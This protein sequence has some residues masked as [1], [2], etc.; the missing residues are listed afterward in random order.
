MTTP[1]I[2]LIDPTGGAMAR[3][4]FALAPRPADL[5]GARLGLLDN[6]KSGSEPI[7]RA[8]AALLK[9]EFQWA[10]VYYAKKHSASLP[11]KPEILESLHRHADVVVTGVG[12]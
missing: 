9:D 1:T 3:E 2:R 11:P 6:S 5:R 4:A 12:D 8:I 7:L 10:D